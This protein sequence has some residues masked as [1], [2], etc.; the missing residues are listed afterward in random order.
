MTASVRGTRV[1]RALALPLL[2]AALASLAACATPVDEGPKPQL[3]GADTQVS[4]KA[5]FY[6]QVLSDAGG[7]TLYQFSGDKGGQPNCYDACAETWQPFI[8]QGVPTPANP[9]VNALEDEVLGT[10]ARKDGQQQVSY[11]GH[12]L[13]FFVGD[14]KPGNIYAPDDV[15]GVGLTQ[16]GGRWNAVT[17]Q[18]GSVSP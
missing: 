8:A 6:G 16:F 15:K 12:P 10:V 7:R 1:R 14:G 11:A 18:G 4:T 3:S 17:T 9:N 13:Y 2:L 5:G